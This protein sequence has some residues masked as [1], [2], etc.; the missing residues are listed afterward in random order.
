MN[1][2]SLRAHQFLNSVHT[3]LLLTAIA[4][5]VSLV[6]WVVFGTTGLVLAGAFALLGLWLSQRASPA[7][8]LRRLGAR[9]LRAWEAPALSRIVDGLSLKAGLSRRP[10]IYAVP[11]PQLNAAAMGSPRDPAIVVS[12][13]LLRSLNERELQGV[14]A[15]EITHLRNNDLKVMTL[16]QR[17]QAY[18]RIMAQIGMLLVLINIPLT[19][20]GAAH[21]SWTAVLV[22]MIAPTIVGLLALALS[23]TREYRADMGAVTLTGDPRGLA[24]ALQKLEAAG[25]GLLERMF[26]V[27]I[28]PRSDWLMSHPATHARIQRLMSLTPA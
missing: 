20:T 1:S 5:V 22:L 9:P 10:Q 12:H 21:I 25:R 28:R 6:G 19:M 3:G 23:R 17:A 2:S 4:G 13:G 14:L 8:A 7:Y 24:S 26:G 18:A 15:H 16:A 27:V 11:S